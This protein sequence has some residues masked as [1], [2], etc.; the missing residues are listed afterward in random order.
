LGLLYLLLLSPRQT[1]RISG[2]P[3]KGMALNGEN[4]VALCSKNT[5]W[6]KGQS[7]HTEAVSVLLLNTTELVQ[8][9]NVM[10]ENILLKT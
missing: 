7:L 4:R 3:I 10:V 8:P 6:V 9:I 1:L 5:A 2:I